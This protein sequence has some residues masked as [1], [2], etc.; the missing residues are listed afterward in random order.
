M[1][2]WIKKNGE[3][4]NG[5][6]HGDSLNPLKKNKGKKDEQK[7]QIKRVD[8]LRIPQNLVIYLKSIGTQNS[9]K[10]M[11]KDLSATGAFVLCQNFHSYPF[12]TQSTILDAFVELLDPDTG[13]VTGLNFLA[14]IAR[15]VEAHGEGATHISGF[16]V[17]I[18]QMDFRER[19]ILEQFIASHGTPDPHAPQHQPQDGEQP[20]HEET[21]E[22]ALNF[23]GGIGSRPEDQSELHEETKDAQHG[24]DTTIEEVS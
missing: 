8:N 16:G 18:V 2:F 14:K 4:E 15:V 11:T 1:A 22:F 10:F 12:Q 5:E 23:N 9:F 21:H 3:D 24:D 6:K 17:R 7:Q 13:K 20:D 19:Q